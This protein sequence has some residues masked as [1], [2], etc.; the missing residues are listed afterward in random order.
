[1]KLAVICNH[2][3]PDL[4]E[5][6]T[7]KS[8]LKNSSL[9]NNLMFLTNYFAKRGG[10]VSKVPSAFSRK[11][12]FDK[13]LLVDILYSPFLAIYLLFKGVKI[14]HFTTSHFSNVPLA[15][16]F[17]LFGKKCI[18][19]IHR[20]DLESY[21]PTRRRLLSLY[22]KL[23]FKIAYKIVILSDH[24]RVPVS[25]KVIIPMAGYKQY[26]TTSKSSADYYM[27]FGRIDDYKG[28]EDIYQLACD[29][30]S[31]KFVV[32]GNGT[33][34][35]ISKLKELNNVDLKNRFIDDSELKDLFGGAKLVLLP[36]KSISQSAVQILS[37]SYATPVVCYDVGNLRE[38]IE[39]GKTGYLVPKGDY[40]EMKRVVENFNDEELIYLSSNAIEYF[41]SKFSDKVLYEQY[42]SFYKS[43]IV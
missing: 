8:K 9:S 31:S 25:K 16:L 7:S 12:F 19:T 30:P 37:Y 2:N 15:M 26:V 27:F 5:F 33:H 34:E 43:M 10:L 3:Y 39:D 24:K 14:V 18:F 41:N 13:F 1:M 32:A 35:Y 38:F 40:A 21:D 20:F 11:P 29:L 36:Y 28:L 4:Q 6:F 23:L 42:E 22:E 17:W